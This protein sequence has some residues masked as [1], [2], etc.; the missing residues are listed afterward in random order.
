MPVMDKTPDFLVY[1]LSACTSRANAA[2]A[3]RSA[4]VRTI[5]DDGEDCGWVVRSGGRKYWQSQCL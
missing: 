5:V 4:V 2:V 3:A 1:M